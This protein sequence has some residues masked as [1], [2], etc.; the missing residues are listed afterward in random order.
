MSRNYGYII[1]TIFVIS[2]FLF[3][4]NFF[5]TKAD[6]TD[7]GPLYDYITPKGPGLFGKNQLN[8]EKY[9]EFMDNV[10]LWKVEKSTDG[11]HFED[12][13]KYEI[14]KTLKDAKIKYTIIV[15]SDED[16]YYKIL[17]N[18][19]INATIISYEDLSTEKNITVN[20]TNITLKKSNDYILEFEGYSIVYNWDDYVNSPIANTTTFKKNVT[21]DT[22][23]VKT[24]E[25]SILSINKIKK[26]ETFILDPSYG[27]ITD[28]AIDSWEIDAQEGRAYSPEVTQRLNNSNFWV[29]SFQ[30]DTGSDLDGFLRT[31]YI[32]DNNGTINKTL[33]DSWE[34]NNGDSWFSQIVKCQDDIYLLAYIASSSAAGYVELRTVQIWESNGTI[35]KDFIDD[36]KLTCND[37]ANGCAIEKIN[38]N[39]FIFVSEEDDGD[40]FL[41]TVEVTH[42][43]LISILDSLE[44]ST[45]GD[46]DYW[47]EATV[48]AVDNDTFA[49]IVQSLDLDYYLYTINVSE[50]GDIAAAVTDTWE[51]YEGLV[52]TGFNNGRKGYR[53][54]EVSDENNIFGIAFGFYGEK[55]NFSTVYIS[56]EGIITK[57]FIDS[58]LVE[59]TYF[60]WK[61]NYFEVADPDVYEEGIYAIVYSG[62]DW[63]GFIKTINVTNDGQI[64]EVI[65]SLEFDE[66]NAAEAIDIDYIGNNYYL[67]SYHSTGDDGWLKVLEIE[68]GGVLAKADDVQIILV[69]PLNQTMG[70]CIDEI[71][72][73]EF[74][75]NI[76]DITG[77]YNMTVE[78]ENTTYTWSDCGTNGTFT[79]ELPTYPLN[80]SQNITWYINITYVYDDPDYVY[81][82]NS[83]WFSTRDDQEP[84][85]NLTYPLNNSINASIWTYLNWEI[86]DTCGDEIEEYTYDVYI[87]ISQ[88]F[89]EEYDKIATNITDNELR[90]N[91]SQYIDFGVPSV[92]MDNT[93]Y[94]WKVVA[95]ENE[96]ISIVSNISN[97]NTEQILALADEENSS[98]IP[99][100]DPVNKNYYIDITF[101]AYLYGH[102]DA[103]EWKPILDTNMTTDVGPYTSYDP[104][105]YGTGIIYHMY[106]VVGEFNNVNDTLSYIISFYIN[107][108][109]ANEVFFVTRAYTQP[110][111]EEIE[112]VMH[113]FILMGQNITINVTEDEIY[114][115]P[116]QYSYLALHGWTY[117]NITTDPNML[118]GVDVDIYNNISGDW[119]KIGERNYSV[120]AGIYP[121]S[122][123]SDPLQ[124]T[125]YNKTH[126]YRI[127]ATLFG[128][129]TNV[130]FNFTTVRSYTELTDNNDY[131]RIDNLSL[132][133]NANPTFYYIL[134][135]EPQNLDFY[136]IDNYTWDHNEKIKIEFTTNATGNWTYLYNF[137]ITNETEQNI[138]TFNNT[139]YLIGND[140]F[141]QPLTWYYINFSSIRLNK[142][143]DEIWPGAE[144]FNLSYKFCLIPIWANFTLE[145][146]DALNH[147]YYINFTGKA[148]TPYF[149][150]WYFGDNTY[151]YENTEKIVKRYAGPGTYI[152]LCSMETQ[153][154]WYYDYKYLNLTIPAVEEYQNV[155]MDIDFT[156]AFWFIAIIILLSLIYV[157]FNMVRGVLNGKKK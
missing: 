108:T 123:Y 140:I 31:Y 19:N 92:L 70:L 107:T 36:N 84:V 1:L 42:D 82:N 138:I 77:Y 34:Y 116:S 142:N 65:D 152:I 6:D 113:T 125:T 157:F 38:D 7:K 151:N 61:L 66:N 104:Y 41:D 15:N 150:N 136:H 156:F 46:V 135:N 145:E 37:I 139:E 149:I 56:D 25:W 126:Y 3:Q 118:Y 51:F 119:E 148:A 50:A 18:N 58:L 78:I 121:F 128:C 153:N 141:N 127:I 96:T 45:Q 20:E 14:K 86:T 114:P 155:K 24:F 12:Y 89:T 110:I 91:G 132:Q 8:E 60:T 83:F 154:G 2:M 57:S 106:P 75:V 94:Y 102:E 68:T 27:I 95:W 71:E 39:Y 147:T 29:S 4:L 90:I 67:L 87:N 9:I 32:N 105:G 115:Y 72:E 144:Y 63:D 88:N 48:C 74:K 111:S 146:K 35:N 23:N 120:M 137:S 47:A 28:P 13:K 112:T 133:T 30:G 97:F 53:I 26:G 117:I 22:S 62:P 52:I 122:L 79:A 11:A 49:I 124:D 21:S 100:Y 5:Y 99:I 59:D 93:T 33:I 54:R 98:V 16:A 85:V 101:G 109:F 81:I 55:L 44:F 10:I 40:Y 69:N 76:T 134:H 43:G 103:V 130:T 64:I 131:P 80:Y 129:E 143:T 73:V 17:T